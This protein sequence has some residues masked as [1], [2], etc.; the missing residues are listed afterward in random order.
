GSRQ[1]LKSRKDELLVLNN[2]KSPV[3][4]AF[5]QIRTNLNFI[6]PDRPIETILVTSSG[7]A[8]GKSMVLAN[9]AIAMVQNGKKVIVI[10]ADLRK[11]MQ[12]KFYEMANFN[13]LSNILTGEID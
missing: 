7:P 2:P 11:P 5:R 4:E 3:A 6:S 10:D 9:L 8:E 12:H 13:G 1:L